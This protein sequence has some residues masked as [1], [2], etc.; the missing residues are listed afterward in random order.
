MWNF[1]EVFPIKV[2]LF[3]NLKL[4]SAFYSWNG[5]RVQVGDIQQLLGGKAHYDYHYCYNLHFATY[6][7]FDQQLKIT[8]RKPLSPPPW[9]N[10]VPPESS[11]S[12]RTPLFA[13]TENFSGHPEKRGVTHNDYYIRCSEKA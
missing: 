9:K 12:A 8:F 11:K 2:C 5:F 10:P 1:Q 13:S 4:M 3:V 6:I 7:I